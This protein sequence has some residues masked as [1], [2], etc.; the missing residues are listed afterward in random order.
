MQ[1]QNSDLRLNLATNDLE[2]IDSAIT[3]TEGARATQQRLQVRAKIFAGEWFLNDSIGIDYYSDILL[4]DPDVSVIET[5]LVDTALSIPRVEEVT[6]VNLEY[7]SGERALAGS[8]EVRTRDGLVKF[9]VVSVW[10]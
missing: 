8:V 3:F 1:N 5:I 4:K 10:V 2:L 9:D 6:A 7:I